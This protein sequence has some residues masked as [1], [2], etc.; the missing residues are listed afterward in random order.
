MNQKPYWWPDAQGFVIIVVMLTCV[1][2]VMLR[3]FAPS[4]TEDKVL[5]MMTQVFFTTGLV[6]IIQFF[7]GTSRSSQNKDDTINRMVAP[8]PPTPPKPGDQP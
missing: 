3:T 4:A 7:F 2:L 8:S 5:D 1:A 6:A